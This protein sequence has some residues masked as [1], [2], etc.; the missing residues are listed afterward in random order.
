MRLDLWT[1]KEE[2]RRRGLTLSEMLARAGVSRNAFYSLAR[3]DSILP[4]S[5]HLVATELQLAPSEILVDEAAQ[6]AGMRVLSAG[7]ENHEK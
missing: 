7:G 3:R 5:L 1:I 2:C 4:R 6:K